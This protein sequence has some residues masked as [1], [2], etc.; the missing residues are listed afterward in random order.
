MMKRLNNVR[1]K[2]GFRVSLLCVAVGLAAASAYGA[3]VTP[4]DLVIYRVGDG[5]AALT[6]A[7]TAVFLDEYTPGGTLV[8]SIPLATTGGSALT[9]NGTASTEG[10]ISGSQ[11]GSTLVFTGYRKDV[12]GTNPASDTYTT[13]SRVIGTIQLAGVPDTSTTVTSDGG[14]TTANTIRS[15]TSVGGTAGSALWVSTSSRISYYGSGIGTSGGTTQIDARNSRQV[16]LLQNTLFASNGST[17]IAAKVQS[18]G[19]LPTG[20]TAGAAIVTEALTDAVNGFAMLDLN[21]GV[22]GIDTVYALVTTTSKLEKWIFNGSA[23]SLSGFVSVGSATNLTTTVS[24]GN[25][26]L[27]LT[28]ASTLSSIVDTSGP[29]GAL[30][31]SLTTLATAGANTAFRGIGAL[32]PEPTTISLLAV[33]GLL[34]TRRRR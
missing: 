28:S 23:W 18:Y 31:G 34:L 22:A 10:I 5:S 1:A 2:S 14:V 6:T 16:N 3:V 19:T 29:T 13:T 15:A 8:Q 25:V 7:A 30:S 12:G 32:V 17:T 20:A 27:Y 4:G 26:N 11:D 33:G 9:A 21:A 24:G